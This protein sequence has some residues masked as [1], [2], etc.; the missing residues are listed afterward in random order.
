MLPDM[1]ATLLVRSPVLGPYA[2]QQV[3]KLTVRVAELTQQLAEA[4]QQA[5]QQASQSE[6]QAAEYEQGG[7]H[8]EQQHR[9]QVEKLQGEVEA[10][11]AQA[12]FLNNGLQTKQA[13]VMQLQSFTL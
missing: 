11:K 13:R 12:V 1:E 4:K 2:A 3:T 8:A 6:A 9:E 10:E 7:R 5:Q